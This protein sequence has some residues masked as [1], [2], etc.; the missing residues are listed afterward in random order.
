[1]TYGFYLDMKSCTGCRTCQIACKDKNDLPIGILYRRV[2]TYEAGVFPKPDLYHLSR[3]C[4]HCENPACVANCPTGAMY[5]DEETGTVQHRDDECIGCQTCVNSCPYEIPQY[6]EDDKIVRKCDMCMDL[7][8][9]GENPACVDACMLRALEWGD[10]DEL[11][12]KHGDSVR[13]MAVLPASSQTGPRSL[14]TVT[15]DALKD[16]YARKYI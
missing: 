16:T 12:A 15:D 5:Q 10:I 11:A 13:D 9:A 4:N 14:Y 7:V 3:T 1:M 6:F 2:E 8:K